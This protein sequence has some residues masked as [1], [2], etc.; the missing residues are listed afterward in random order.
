[1]DARLLTSRARCQ[2]LKKACQTSASNRKRSIKKPFVSRTARLEQKVDGLV[3]L[4]HSQS[5]LNHLHPGP[6]DTTL[7]PIQ[8]AQFAIPT[9][10]ASLNASP[11]EVSD[12]ISETMTPDALAEE[13]L[14]KFR[15]S[16]LPFFPFVYIPATMS[17][18]NLRI[19]KPFLSLVIL[20]LT[21]K[22]ASQ[23][24]RLF[25][26]IRQVVSEKV[27]AEHERSLDIL[28]GLICYLAWLFPPIAFNCRL[29]TEIKVPISKKQ[30]GF[31]YVDTSS[32]GI[33]IR[34]WT[35]QS[36]L[37]RRGTRLCEGELD[38]F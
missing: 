32:R 36:P 7:L 19:Q 3:S 26:N 25:D 2:R 35:A 37:T 31:G 16:F 17:A 6:S 34:T 9:P 10:Q 1:L 21:T 27:L 11:T 15:Q 24:L 14:A 22:S 38:F 23:Q 20:S 13:Q 4:L 5:T 28:L 8:S 33:S 18:S 12:C 29:L 30:V